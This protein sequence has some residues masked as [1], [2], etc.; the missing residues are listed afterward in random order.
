LSE[1]IL[2]QNQQT[3]IHFPLETTNQLIMKKT[4]LTSFATCAILA[5]SA[6]AANLASGGDIGNITVAAG[7]Y[8][9]AGYTVGAMPTNINS[10]DPLTIT[11]ARYETIIQQNND[12]TS[13][14]NINGGTVDGS[15]A[16]G[17]GTTFWLGNEAGSTGV[18]NMNSGT[19]DGS[20]FTSFLFG[21]NGGVGILNLAGGTFSIGSAPTIGGSD[22]LN[23]T[24]GSTGS[25]D[26]TGWTQTDYE[27]LWNSGNLTVNGGQTGDFS[28]NFQVTGSTLTT[29]PEPSSAALLGLGGIAL[30]LRRRK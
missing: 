4:I 9:Q 10:G 21:R 29:V 26:V 6:S 1:K 7:D 25:F 12:G 17:N 24:T 5:T 27:A 20:G 18:I 2:Q 15:G 13:T 19:F 11:N 14:W 16:S 3:P 8:W 30:I 23:F 22:R 28:D